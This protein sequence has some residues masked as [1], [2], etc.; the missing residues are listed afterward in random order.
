MDHEPVTISDSG[1]AP[2]TVCAA[3]GEPWPCA[4]S[5]EQAPTPATLD[6]GAVTVGV[7]DHR[8]QPTET[9]PLTPVSPVP[10]GIEPPA[11]WEGI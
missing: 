7:T 9:M 2:R 11:P 6:V 5:G 10:G 4:E 8:M 3:C 1:S